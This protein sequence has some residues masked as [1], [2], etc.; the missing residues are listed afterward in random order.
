MTD[1]IPLTALT[2]TQ[3]EKALARFAIIR[4]FL[5]EGVSLTHIAQQ[6][7]MQL[8]TLQSWV[9]RYRRYG[10]AGLARKGRTD[11]GQRRIPSEMAK[12]IEGLA[13]SKPRPTFSYIHRQVVTI[14][15]REGWK[16]PS[17]SLVKLV[18]SQ[19]EPALVALAHEGAKAYQ[20]EY[21]LLYRREGTRPNDIWQAD[22][23]PLDIWLLNEEGRPANPG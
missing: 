3:R 6:H 23:S 14:A 18:V 13:L 1:R 5:E 11:R 7:T 16:A 15:Q 19:L 22:H 9:Q 4:P 21:D 17:Y 10:L 8:R 12:L 20:E 2:E